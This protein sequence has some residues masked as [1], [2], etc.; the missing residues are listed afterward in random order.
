V[1]PRLVSG[2]VAL[3]ALLFTLRAPAEA[4][5]DREDGGFE[6]SDAITEGSDASAEASSDADDAAN[7]D[8]TDSAIPDFDD[9]AKPDATGG[10]AGNGGSAGNSGDISTGFDGA[11]AGHAGTTTGTAGTTVPASTNDSGCSCSVLNRGASSNGWLAFLGLGAL[12]WVMRGRRSKP[13]T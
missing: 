13:S 5:P 6:A 12:A 9:A 10:A 11:T 8:A 7:A 3:A 4:A 1:S 2:G